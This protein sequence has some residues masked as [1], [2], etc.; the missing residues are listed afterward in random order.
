VWTPTGQ[1]HDS[2]YQFAIARVGQFGELFHYHWLIATV[3]QCAQLRH[4]PE[5]WRRPFAHQ[6][7]KKWPV[8]LAAWTG[9]LRAPAF[10]TAEAGPARVSA[11]EAVQAPA[12][13]EPVLKVV[14]PPQ[15]APRSFLTSAT[16]PE[17]PAALARPNEAAAHL[18]ALRASP[19]ADFAVFAKDDR[20]FHL[21]F[22]GEPMALSD[23]MATALSAIPRRRFLVTLRSPRDRRT[24]YRSRA[25]APIIPG[26]SL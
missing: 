19:Q 23:R 6:S 21:C 14:A 20:R 10:A 3:H 2:R 16:I 4:D 12:S 22:P 1:F 26:I 15:S 24:A 8:D 13:V 11:S 7:S 9:A 18:N 25:A 17:R 5:V